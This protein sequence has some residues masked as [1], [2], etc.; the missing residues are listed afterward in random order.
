[1]EVAIS[2]VIDKKRSDKKEQAAS[3][4]LDPVTI[5]K[6]YLLRDKINQ[7]GYGRKVMDREIISLGLNLITD[8]HIK[9]LQ[10]KTYSEMDRL[11]IA[12]ESYAKR[13]GK[14]S[15]DEFVGKLLRGEIKE[16]EFNN[17]VVS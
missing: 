11:N 9:K 14:L 15:F 3:K 6:L 4:K 13:N 2:K 7:K 17:Q 5:N 8:E 12:F 16:S 10:E 1:V